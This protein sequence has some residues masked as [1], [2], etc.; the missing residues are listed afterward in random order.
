MNLEVYTFLMGPFQFFGLIQLE[1][2]K[3]SNLYSVKSSH[4]HERSYA[5]SDESK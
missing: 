5:T 2:R 1:T 3:L 4:V